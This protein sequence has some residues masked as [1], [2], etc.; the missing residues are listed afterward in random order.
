MSLKFIVPAA[1][2]GED[3][4]EVPREVEAKGPE[5]LEQFYFAQCEL[6]KAEEE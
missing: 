2:G 4:V 3:I 5:A 6:R 1:K